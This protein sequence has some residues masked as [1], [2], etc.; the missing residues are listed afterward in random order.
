MS[1]FFFKVNI[2]IPYWKKDSP[3]KKFS[4]VSSALSNVPPNHPS[5]AL[6]PGRMISNAFYEPKLYQFDLE[7]AVFDF[8]ITNHSQ[9]APPPPSNDRK[10]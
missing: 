10:S 6:H 4:F 3:D 7:N 2:S 8:S 1:V 9:S 5:S